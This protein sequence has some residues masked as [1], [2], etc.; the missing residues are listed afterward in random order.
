MIFVYIKIAPLYAAIFIVFYFSSTYINTQYFLTFT[1]SKKTG[2]ITRCTLLQSNYISEDILGDDDCLVAVRADGGDAETDARDLCHAREVLLG[3]L[4]QVF[5]L[6]D[7]ADIALP[8]RERLIDRLDF[9][10]DL[11]AGRDLVED[12]ALVL[13]GDA[14]LDLVEAVEDV[15]A[16]DGHVIDARDQ[17]R[18]AHDAGIE[19]ARATRTARDDAVLVAFLADL[20]ADGVELL[21]RERALADAR[22]VRL[23]DADDL[24]DLL[25]RDARAD[26]DAAGDGV[27]GRDIGVCAVVDVEHRR[28]R[29]LEEDLAALRDLLVEQRDR[30]ADVRAQAVGVAVIL[31]EH[32][33][34][35]ERLVV[36]EEPQLLVLDGEVFLQT[37]RELVLIDE[38]ADADADAVVAVHVA[39]ADAAVRRA[40]LVLAA[41]LVADAVHEAVIRE[42]DMRAVADADAGEVDAARRERVHLLEH[43]L[44]VEGD[45]VA[46]DAVR[47]L[48]QDARRHEAQLVCF[49][50]DDDGMAGVAAALVAHDRLSL[51]GEIVDDLALSLVAPLR[52]GY[53]YC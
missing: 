42:H 18:I 28:L 51:L 43:D 1:Q 48:E 2:C 34:V 41:R 19:P 50:I 4:R 37:A 22:A 23:D 9:R 16:R 7:L 36:V 27:R 24:V 25:R 20:V 38:V 5:V 47:A 40:D 21:R 52:T 49:I 46:D 30:V 17:P 29:A 11:E 45:A 15:E 3:I 14:H 31:R 39:G 8:A 10:E 32:R 33:V 12:L 13:V 26:G 44:R 53:Y 6:A 35:V